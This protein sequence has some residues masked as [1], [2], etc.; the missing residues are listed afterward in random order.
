VNDPR[1]LAPKGWHIPSSTEIDNLIKFLGGKETGGGKLKAI[2]ANYWLN[3]NVGAT[4]ET[5]FNGLPGGYRSNL[6]DFRSVG[7]YGAWWISFEFDN[8]DAGN[9][10]LYNQ[11]NSIGIWILSKTNGFS[12]RCIKDE[13]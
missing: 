2:S 8:L 13:Q 12:V 5:E 4:N 3:P 1:G 10:N 6:G 7:E 9:F 11:D